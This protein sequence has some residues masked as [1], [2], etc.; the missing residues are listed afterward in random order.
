MQSVR[1]E[2]YSQNTLSE[3]QIASLRRLGVDEGTLLVAGAWFTAAVRFMPPLFDFSSETDEARHALLIPVYDGDVLTDICAVDPRQPDTFATRDG[4]AEYLGADDYGMACAVGCGLKVYRNPIS[5]M[6]D[7]MDGIVILDRTSTWR[8][9]RDIPR[10][11]AEDK[12]HAR[13]IKRL[14]QPPPWQGE[15]F[16][17]ESKEQQAA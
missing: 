13:E 9:L 6:Q 4:R 2:L 1:R 3:M 16:H 7:D 15:V 12:Q 11:I 10:I 5:W 8:I 14:I 17:F